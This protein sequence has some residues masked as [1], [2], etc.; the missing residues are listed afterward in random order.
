MAMKM[1]RRT[2]LKTT[3]AAAVAVSM[4][5]LLGGCS[6]AA[7]SGIKLDGYTIG[8]DMNEATKSWGG[9]AGAGEDE[10]TGYLRATFKIKADSG[11][12]L[13]IPNSRFSGMTSTGDALTL[14]NRRLNMVVLVPNVS[15]PVEV[16]FSTKDK[17]VYD[18]LVAGT[19]TLLVNINPTGG[20]K[21][22]QYA[23]NYATK[24]AVGNVVDLETN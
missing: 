13:N 17:K 20:D 12:D 23:I 5:G 16:K 14:E 18:A 10:E 21:A 6:D 1:N 19:P 3:A 7:D 2:F 22:V 15:I 24:E 9:A 11:V 4:T 8:I